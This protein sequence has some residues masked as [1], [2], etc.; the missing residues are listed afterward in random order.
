MASSLPVDLSLL[1]SDSEESAPRPVQVKLEDEEPPQMK[2][3][4]REEPLQRP[5][6]AHPSTLTLDRPAWPPNE[7]R[8]VR[9]MEYTGTLLSHNHL[10]LSLSASADII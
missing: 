4:Q 1:P 8:F 9:R 2:E 10:C 5:Q 7:S 6:G 3:E